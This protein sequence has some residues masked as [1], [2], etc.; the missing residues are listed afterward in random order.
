MKE[1]EEMEK[2]EKRDVDEKAE[3]GRR[4]ENER[5][6]PDENE[7]AGT[8][9]ISHRADVALAASWPPATALKRTV[10]SLL[11]K[12]IADEEDPKRAPLRNAVAG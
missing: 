6:Q 7:K 3:S 2:E 9:R 5:V 8:T 11:H 10:I 12:R 1:Q 4:R